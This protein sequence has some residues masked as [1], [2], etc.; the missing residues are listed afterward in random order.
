M[1]PGR[2]LQLLS[3][4]ETKLVD[5]LFGRDLKRLTVAF[6]APERQSGCS[7]LV[8][9]ITERLAAR[10]GGSVCT[11]DANLHWP[12]LHDLFGVPNCRGLLQ[13]VTQL[14]EPIR[15]F[16][17][18]IEGSNLWIIPSGG[19]LPDSTTLLSSENMKV[20][21]RELACEFDYV[22]IDTPAMKPCADSGVIGRLTDGIVIVIAANSDK[23]DSTENTK[24]LLDAANT[25]ILGAVLNKRTFPIP[26]SVYQYL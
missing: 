17:M 12:A 22:L 8:S 11:V 25:R 19:P 20:R 10:T 14:D 16:A 7:W 26:D 1:T 24:M 15:S 13:A 6:T 23:R 4:E 2:M 3:E 9:R 18:P 21:M 5:N